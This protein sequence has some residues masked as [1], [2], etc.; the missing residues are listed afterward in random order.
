M[1]LVLYQLPHAS[2][3]E[4]PVRAMNLRMGDQLWLVGYS[5]AGSLEVGRGDVLAFSLYWRAE[6]AVE[7]DYVVFAQL[8]DQGGRLC[9]QVDRRPRGG[10]RPTYTWQPDEVIRD[11]YGLTVPSDLP[12]GRYQ[13]I[14]GLYLPATM[15]RLPVATADGKPVGDHAILTQVPVEQA[16]R[17]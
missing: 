4:H 14:T 2:G 7:Q 12:A 5:Q 9:A 10:F 17:P 8:L 6:Y 16:D 11:N 13:L 1:R 3:V 15:Q